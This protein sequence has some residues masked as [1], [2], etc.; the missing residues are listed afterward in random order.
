MLINSCILLAPVILA[1][2]YPQVAKLA[3]LLG[4]VGGTLAIY[5]VPTITYVAQS[6]MAIKN[7]RLV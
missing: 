1:I 5:I 7:P 4:A 2:F 3:A 6:H